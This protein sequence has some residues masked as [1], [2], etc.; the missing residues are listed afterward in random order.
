MVGGGA[1]AGGDSKEDKAAAKKAARE[2]ERAAKAAAEEQARVAQVIR[3]RLAEGQILQLKSTIQDKIAAAEAAGDKQL[4]ARL[5]GQ[6]KE[7][8]IQ[9][10]YAQSLAQEKDIRAQ[11]AIIYEGNT[12]LV[13]NQRE[14]Q[15]ELNELQKQGDQDR[16]NALQKHI[17]KQY[18]LNTG[19]Q[20]Q[21]KLADGVANTLGQGIGSAFNALISGAQSWESSLQQIASG[22]LIDIA[23][24]L[25]RIFVIE[26]AINAIKTFLTP[27]SPSTPLGAGGGTVGRFG[28]FGPNYGIPQRAKGGSVMAGQPYLV[29]ER[30]PELFMPGRS[31]GIARTG[32]F[33]GA[34]S[35]VVN[36]DAGGTSVEGN[37][38]NANQL[39]RIVGAAVQAEIVKQQR[40]GGLLANTR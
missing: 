22:V 1:G 8:D 14:V 9:Y 4:A 27:F 28:T 2:A 12:A 32:S 11:E 15:R 10:R 21:L 23:N 19:V 40:P 7:L 16:L 38:P 26:Q 30:G 34:V 3:E 6:E 17:E 18:E 31:G 33:G 35:V 37:E 39:G 25:V 20:N 5:K 29:G 36:V 24:Q 13:A